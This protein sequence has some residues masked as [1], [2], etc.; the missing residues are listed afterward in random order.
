NW[1]RSGMLPTAIVAPF[2]QQTTLAVQ[3]DG[4]LS[5][6]TNPAGEFEQFTYNGG[7]AEGLL[8]TRSD[9]RGNV[10]HYVYDALGRLIRDENPAGGVKILA[11]NDITT[12]YYTVSVTTALGLVTTYE[13]EE[14]SNGDLR[15]A[16][17]EPSGARTESINRADGSRRVTYPDG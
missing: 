10:H 15:R 14:L 4:F 7:N 13:V 5:R 3:A 16:R 2:G 12:D 1:Q 8:S 6:V 17:I 9:A 11:R